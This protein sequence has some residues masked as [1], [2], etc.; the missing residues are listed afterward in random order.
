MQN[1]IAQTMRKHGLAPQN[2]GSLADASPT[3]G[4]GGNAPL[5]HMKVHGKWSYST[6]QYPED[7]QSR[8]DLGHYMMFYIN[9]ADSPRSQYSTYDSMKEKQLEKRD[10][11]SRD[12][13]KREATQSLDPSQ[14][15]VR[16]GTFHS[17]KSGV[18]GRDNT[19]NS[20]TPGET[21]KVIAR[22]P[23]QGELSKRF[24]VP[25]TKRTKDSI[26][27][28]MPPNLQVNH[29]AVYK[30]N[31]MGGMGMETGQRIQS[32]VSRAQ[33]LGGGFSGALD[34]AIEALPGFGQQAGREALRVG[35]KIGSEIIGGDIM[36]GVD[37]MSN[38]AENK[39]L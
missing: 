11:R 8:S 15:A 19:G 12:T 38:R 24:K 39:F 18:K 6:L 37:K 27:L 3:R 16:D 5:Q 4:G 22:K 36:A 20:W 30:Q 7:I 33:A 13:S 26:I 2:K 32:M 34:A 29:N 23:F 21:E 31:E 17:N 1:F 35:A 28:Y 9:V 25:R 14:Q 10:P